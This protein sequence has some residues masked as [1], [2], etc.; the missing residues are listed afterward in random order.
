MLFSATTPNYA[1]T[2]VASLNFAG[3]DGPVA[4]EDRRR[5]A[6]VASELVNHRL[7]ELGWDQAELSRQ[8]EVSPGTLRPLQRGEVHTYRASNLAKVSRALGWPPG[9]L[10]AVLSGSQSESPQVAAPGPT[11]HPAAASGMDLSDLSAED[12][13]RVEGFVE[14]LRLRRERR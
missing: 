8:S 11:A 14:A 6:Q 13:A 2:V 10:T 7:A 9:R 12:R 3:K 1:Q 5:W 4:D